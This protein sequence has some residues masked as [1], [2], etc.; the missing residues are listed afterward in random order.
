MGVAVERELTGHTLREGFKCG[1][2]CLAE[3]RKDVLALSVLVEILIVGTVSGEQ[4]VE[5]LDQT[6]DSGDELD[7]SLRNKHNTEVVALACAVSNGLC[8]LLYYLVQGEVLLLDLLRD[9]AD[10]RL[11]LES[12]LESDV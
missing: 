12:T 6:A 3:V 2:V 4:V 11:C 5:L 1:L 7:E 9:E 8:D 10:V